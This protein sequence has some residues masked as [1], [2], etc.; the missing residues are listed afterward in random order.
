MADSE[1]LEALAQLIKECSISD[2]RKFLSREA[3]GEVNFLDVES[4]FERMIIPGLHDLKKVELDKLDDQAVSKLRLTL[5]DLATKFGAINGFSIRDPDPVTRRDQIAKEVTAAATGFFNIVRTFLPYYLVHAM[6]GE[7]E[8]AETLTALKD[9]MVEAQTDRESV[10][11]IKLETEDLLV[12]AK[13]AAAETGIEQF[14]PS[15]STEARNRARLSKIWLGFSASFASLAL[16]FAFWLFIGGNGQLTTQI[17]EAETSSAILSED[18]TLPSSDGAEFE[19]GSDFSSQPEGGEN[20]IQSHTEP[21]PKDD[22]PAA[23]TS[24]LTVLE[25]LAGKFAVLGLLA[26]AAIWCGRQYNI[27]QHLRAANQ[28]RS[29]SLRTFRAFVDAAQTLKGRDQVLQEA[30]KAI[31]NP[32]PTGHIQST[33]DDSSNSSTVIEIVDRVSSKLDSD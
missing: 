6:E 28:H 2:V 20:N 8:A 5:T 15:F 23:P 13:T 24:F 10:E 29:D 11:R 12:S 30:T 33:S 32:V 21:A 4:D 18:L 14:T 9:L 26:S 19:A 17:T 16:G 3:W 22:K 25:S 27:Q 7:R 1:T 31:F